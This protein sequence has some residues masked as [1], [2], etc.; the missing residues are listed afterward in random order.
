MLYKFRLLFCKVFIFTLLFLLIVV[1]TSAAN[2]PMT[3]QKTFGGNN[4]DYGRCVI[5]T[6]KGFLVVGAT[7]SYGSG[8]FDV[9]VLRLDFYGNKIWHK[10]FGGKADD[11]ALCGIKAKGGYLIVGWTKS[12]GAGKSDF[13][14]LRIDEEG[15]KLWEKT[16][17][18]PEDD[19]AYR[20]LA[21]NDGFIVVGNTRSIEGLSSQAY[22]IKIDE[23][24]KVIW[25]K[26]YGTQSDEALFGIESTSNGYLAVGQSNKSGNFDAYFL[27]M[28][29]NGE[30][31]K[32]EYLGGPYED[33]IYCVKRTTDG[34]HIA[35]GASEYPQYNR[36][37]Y[38]VKLD[39]NGAVVWEKVYRE[40]KPDV[41][42]CVVETVDGG[43]LVFG[44]TYSYG[45][46]YDDLYLLKIDSRGEK[47]WMKTHGGKG[48]DL[49]YCIDKTADGGF[50][51][52]GDTTST[53]SGG[54][55][56]YILKTN[57]L[58]EISN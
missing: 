18:G 39:N 11:I 42:R 46:G 17:G 15:N 26:N 13:Y 33:F 28:D 21:T 5:S 50:V 43:Y 47:M 55:D 9:Y 53:G 23:E 4:V 37:F 58:G 49:G 14:V 30:K 1:S 36:N 22:V 48:F 35:V 57:E 3:W 10:T 31:I 24:G 27:W 54:F 6:E 25:E 32:E 40:P 41:A 20:A 16:Y 44:S 34:G 45:A 29:R 2:N 19:Y 38:I 12:F 51:M 8:G 7:S 52:V 56:I